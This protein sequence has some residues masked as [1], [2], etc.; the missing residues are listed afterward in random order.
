MELIFTLV[1]EESARSLSLME[2]KEKSFQNFFSQDLSAGNGNNIYLK[3]IIYLKNNY[4]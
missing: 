3:M 1:Q 4:L 2:E